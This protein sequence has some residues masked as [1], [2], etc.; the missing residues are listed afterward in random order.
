MEKHKWIT[1]VFSSLLFRSSITLGFTVGITVNSG[2][3]LAE[4]VTNKSDVRKNLETNNWTVI[5]SEE[6]GTD[7]WVQ[8]TLALTADAFGCSGGCTSAFIQGFGYQSYNTIVQELGRKSPDLVNS[9]RSAMTK[10]D[11][12]SLL[13]SALK[14]GRIESRNLPGVRFEL[15][16]ATYN[17]KECKT[18]WGVRVCIPLPN[19]HQ[20]YVRVKFLVGSPPV[21]PNQSICF[22]VSSRQG[23][24]YFDLPKSVN[25]V[26]GITGSWS[27]DDRNYSRVGASGHTGEAANR[28][29]PYNQYKYAQNYPFGI[30]FVDIPTDSYGF[31]PVTNPQTLPRSINRTAM[32][33]NDADNALGDNAGSL[34]VC[35]GN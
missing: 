33:I 15:G 2:E 19:S 29:A 12:G 28:L 3:A 11:F 23:W 17:R 18:I 16:K 31:I 35:F 7:D 6:F 27:V 34:K 20:P 5:Y 21:P 26:T 1:S 9:F 30:L 14:N 8:L 13:A 22:D 10:T 24:Q 4:H 25:R 32:R